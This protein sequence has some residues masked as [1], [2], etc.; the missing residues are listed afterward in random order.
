MELDKNKHE[1]KWDDIKRD[2][3]ERLILNYFR[4]KLKYLRKRKILKFNGNGKGT[5]TERKG[6][7]IHQN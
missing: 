4:R 3:R 6:E 5:E 1:M 2:I 7:S